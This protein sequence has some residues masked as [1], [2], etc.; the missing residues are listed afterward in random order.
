M[1][2]KRSEQSGMR[3]PKHGEW[4]PCHPHDVYELLKLG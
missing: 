2:A 1:L 3:L 4:E